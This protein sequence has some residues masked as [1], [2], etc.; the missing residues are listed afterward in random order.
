[1]T[2]TGL[3]DTTVPA[4]P[5]VTLPA[6]VGATTVSAVP[7]TVTGEANDFVSWAI[8]DS[9]GQNTADGAFLSS[10]GTLSTTVDLS[11]FADGTI[12]FM[13][14]QQDTAG[15]ISAATTRTLTK[16]SGAPPAPTLTLPTYVNANNQ[17]SVSFTIS[18]EANDTAS[19]TITSSGGSGSVT[20]TA[21]LSSSGSVTV[22]LNLSTLRDGTLSATAT[23][24]DSLGN[25]GPAGTTTATK[26][27]VR[28]AAPTVVLDPAS[29]SGVSSSDYITKVTVPVFDTTTAPGTT[30]AV[31]VNGVAYTNQ[32]LAAG[33]Y[34]VTAVATDQ[35]GNTATATAPKTLVIDTTGPAGSWTVSGGKTIGG[36]LSTTSGSPTLSLSFT[37]A[38]S[39]IA[40]MAVSVDG[41]HTFG[42]S[43]GNAGTVGVTLGADG[44][45]TIVVQLTDTAGN[46]TSSTQTV[47]VDSG[48]PTITPTLS[49]PQ[50][51]IGYDGTANITASWTTS[52]ISSVVSSTATLDGVAFTPGTIDVTTLLAGDHHLIITAV[53]GLGNTSTLS[54]TISVHPSLAGIKNAVNVGNTK[55]LVSNSEKTKLLSFL[56]GS[57]TTLTAGLNNF[58]AECKAQSGTKNLTAAESTLLQSWAADLQSRPH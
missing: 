19:Y 7:L 39:G 42:P 30:L 14:T 12:T 51:T 50:S 48:G 16:K 36:Q 46:V 11:L 26:A 40:S 38:G 34:T 20:G 23:L 29:D 25:V 22:S 21:V 49:A 18:G 2:A 6:T 5:G 32:T 8:S 28:P 27:T 47:R 43:Q 37:D 54:V 15:N 45:Y 4:A 1:V 31:F 52:D 9:R 10:G 3:L 13:I 55:G 33:S 53:D 57:G 35:A 56:T 24:K 58:I 17:G 44:L 41:G